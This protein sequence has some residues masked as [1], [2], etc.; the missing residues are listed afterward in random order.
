[1]YNDG[2]SSVMERNIGPH[3]HVVEIY[4][5][6]EVYAVCIKCGMHDWSTPEEVQNADIGDYIAFFQERY[7]QNTIVRL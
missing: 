2:R 7:P 6:Y 4:V 3:E 5:S 1:M